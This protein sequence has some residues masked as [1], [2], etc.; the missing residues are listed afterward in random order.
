MTQ[1]GGAEESMNVETQDILNES[2]KRLTDNADHTIQALAQH[3]ETTTKAIAT[4]KSKSR[5]TL[6]FTDDS[7]SDLEIIG[8]P[9][10]AQSSLKSPGITKTVTYQQT[11]TSKITPTTKSQPRKQHNT[12]LSDDS[13]TPTI[14]NQDTIGHNVRQMSHRDLNAMLQ[15]KIAI[16][17][18]ER[19]KK[20]E[21]DAKARGMWKSAEEIMKE[22]VDR[23]KELERIKAEVE[24]RLKGTEKAKKDDEADNDYAPDEEDFE[25]ELDFEAL[26]LGS[27]SEESGSDGEGESASQE[28]I[29]CLIILLY[30]LTVYIQSVLTN[31]DAVKNRRLATR[32]TRLTMIPCIMYSQTQ[33]RKPKVK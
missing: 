15:Q 2:V 14:V 33:R 29:V 24:R 31:F 7:D 19:R 5:K 17:M 13:K 3:D 28:E 6:S 18:R 1:R 26:E 27:A 12:S 23:E 8:R 4:V 10:P 9:G 20:A 22:Q 32:S 30:A 21:G 16:Y 11:H 25:E